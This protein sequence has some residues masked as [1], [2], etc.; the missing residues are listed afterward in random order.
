MR[1]AVH[2]VVVV[3][4]G[5]AGCVL[6]ARLSEDASRRVLLLEAGPDYAT[7][8]ATPPD[9]LN[10]RE[11]CY[12]PAYDWGFFSEPDVAGRRLQLWRARVVGGCSATNGAMALRGAPSDYDAWAAAGNPG[13]SFVDVLPFFKALES[14]ADFR[15][16]W[17]G[18]AGPLP[19][20]RSHM[21]QLTDLQRAFWE[22]ATRS[23]HSVAQDHNAPGAMGVGP[24]PRNAQNRTRMSTALT[25]LA[26]ARGRPNLEIRAGMTADRIAI[27]SGRAVGVILASGETIT[28][29]Q[30]VLAAGAY[31]SPALLLRSGIGPAGDLRQLGISVKAELPGVGVGLID[32]PLLGVDFAYAGALEAADKYQ[33]V[34]T[35]RSA[36]APTPA[37]DLQIFAAGPFA[38][39][40]SPTGAVFALV[41]SVV[42]P[43]SRGSVRL[44]SSNPTD[45]PRI[46]PGYLTHAA[47]LKRMVEVVKEARR[48]CRQAPLAA[49]AAGPEL[50]PGADGDSDLGVAIRS[51]VG[52]YHHPVGTCRMG[53]DRD[54]S[55]VVNARGE[56]YGVDGLRVADASIMPDIPS[57]NTNLPAIMVAERLAALIAVSS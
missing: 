29:G 23:G 54:D 8:E 4:A 45:A 49:L 7:P 52:T 44:R 41:V 18:G 16:E 19:I 31:A 25:Y 14:D 50:A 24:L 2:D 30:V 39:A 1:S 48:L 17:H 51:R 28:A 33:V 11:V 15:D 6:A 32:H 22:S 27:E 43:L 40:E 9:I 12:N 20:E 55:A 38:A 3:G 47:D 42:K 13:W 46:D 57:A 36:D 34:L 10:A 53:P 5:S 56:V 37:P 35:L 21:E 26:R